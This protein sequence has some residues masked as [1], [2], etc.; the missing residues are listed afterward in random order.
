MPQPVV[1]FEVV[2]Q[3]PTRLRS[4]FGDLFG[5]VFEVLRRWRKR[6]RSLRATGF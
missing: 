6:C 5:C 1:H 4:Y 3:D 2:G